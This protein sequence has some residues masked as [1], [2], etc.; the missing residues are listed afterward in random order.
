MSRNVYDVVTI[1]GG[2]AGSCLAKSMAEKGARVLVLERETV[3]KD[4][5]RGE[6]MTPWGVGEARQLGIYELLRESCA[7]SPKWFD[8]YL[9]PI[10]MMHRDLSATTPQGA[11]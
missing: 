11:P 4:R 5:V 9:G 7:H 2:I 3:F 1:G 8:L 6:A 10:Q